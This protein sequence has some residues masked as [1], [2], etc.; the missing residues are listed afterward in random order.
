MIQKYTN[1]FTT[2]DLL[3]ILTSTEPQA[4]FVLFA[5]ALFHCARAMV[6]N[7]APTVRTTAHSVLWL[8]ASHGIPKLQY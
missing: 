5:N 7:A 3:K 6:S 4:I 8:S 1:T 2:N